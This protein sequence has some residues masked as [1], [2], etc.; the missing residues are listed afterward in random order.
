M[1]AFNR[2][3]ISQWG[4]VTRR[5]FPLSAGEVGE[6]VSNPSLPPLPTDQ[7]MDIL[8]ILRPRNFEELLKSYLRS[9]LCKTGQ[10][11]VYKFITV[12]VF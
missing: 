8:T 3:G 1:T 4:T 6:R 2:I 5:P 7:L 12:G 10:I 9:P 11:L